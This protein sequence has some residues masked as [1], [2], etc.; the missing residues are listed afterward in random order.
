[1]KKFL[2]VL[3]LVALSLFL[4]NRCLTLNKF[5]Y[6]DQELDEHYQNKKVRPL[7]K[8]A[9]FLDSKLHYAVLS[10]N[11]TLPLLVMVHGGPGAW[12]GYLNLIDDS[13]LQNNFKIVS[14]DR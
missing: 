11:D 13:L 3:A 14:V 1:M 7:Y 4:F 12:Y 8:N 9:R 5:V 2:A 6:S 10:K